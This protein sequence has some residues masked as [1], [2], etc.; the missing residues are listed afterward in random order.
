MFALIAAVLLASA[1]WAEPAPVQR[2]ESYFRYQGDLPLCA[3]WTELGVLEAYTGDKFD[4]Q[5]ILGWYVAAGIFDV[6]DPGV[7]PQ[8]VGQALSVKGVASRLREYPNLN[9]MLWDVRRGFA[10]MALV[11]PHHYWTP[12][13]PM[14]DFYD[15]IA[16]RR[17]RGLA[18][19]IVWV[20]DASDEYV[21]L[22]DT[23]LK[24]GQGLRVSRADFEKAWV[25]AGSR[26]VVVEKLLPPLDAGTGAPVQDADHD[27]FVSVAGGGLDCDDTDPGISPNGVEVPLDGIDQDCSG[28]DAGDEDGD[29][30]PEF[31]ANGQMVDCNDR[32]DRIHPGA[33]DTPY[34]GID[35]DCNRASDF[36][37]DKDG[38][39]SRPPHLGSDLARRIES[40]GLTDAEIEDVLRHVQAL[41]DDD[42]IEFD[43]DDR[44]RFVYPGM[45]EVCGDG[46]DNDCNGT[47]DEGGVSVVGGRQFCTDSDGDGHCPEG[48]E[49]VSHC[50]DIPPPGFGLLGSASDCNDRNRSISPTAGEW[51]NGFDD[52]CD[53]LIDMADDDVTGTVFLFEDRDGDGIGGVEVEVCKG[54]AGYSRVGGDCD[55]L[56]PDGCNSHT[57]TCLMSRG[58]SAGGSSC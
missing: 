8:H 22:H 34:D 55:D 37:V 21:W 51:C 24:R 39:Q 33:L 52:D 5:L 9:R 17:G 58:R 16:V 12:S 4:G 53:G 38:F 2:L 36:D 43:C 50:S 7:A 3:V 27:G 30:Y 41:S 54:S 15:D 31:D 19:H 47:V 49:V 46:I 28:G 26:A 23:A 18:S 20:L 6:E 11:N 57:A 40:Y 10:V 48:A 35:A 25:V 1:G 56:N 32:N 45:D 14:V 29:G 44:S 13:D 42:A